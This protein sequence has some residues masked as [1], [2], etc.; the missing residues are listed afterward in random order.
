[1]AQLY[2]LPYS[3]SYP[4]AGDYKQRLQDTYSGYKSRYIDSY[5]TG[6]VHDPSKADDPGTPGFNED[7]WATSEGVG[8]GLT[9]ALYQNDQ[10]YFDKILDATYTYM[11]NKNGKGLFTSKVD[12]NGNIDPSD[13]DS[14][15]DAD[16][17]ITLALIFADTLVKKGHWANTGRNYGGKAQNLINA[18]YANDIES[19]RYL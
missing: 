3:A 7:D 12:K 11:Y 17:I 4:S 13:K 16:I 8:Y 9:R 1:M 14:A 10:A 15:T 6:L 18:I 19:G 2:F 5:A